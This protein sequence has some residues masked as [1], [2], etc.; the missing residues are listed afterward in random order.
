MILL[1]SRPHFR[2]LWV[3]KNCQ[4]VL[5]H[6]PSKYY[7]LINKSQTWF[8]FL[9]VTEHKSKKTE[10]DDVLIK[11]FIVCLNK[12]S[13]WRILYENSHKNINTTCQELLQSNWSFKD[14]KFWQLSESLDTACTNIL[15]DTWRNV[16][17]VDI[18]LQ[19]TDKLKLTKLTS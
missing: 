15:I 11:R 10:F 6:Q 7:V 2:T 14:Y 4:C 3:S 17:W 13:F 16:A 19:C 5:T 18:S 1:M 8:H 12:I 9:Q